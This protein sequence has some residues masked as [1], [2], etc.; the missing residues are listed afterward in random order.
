MAKEGEET[1]EKEVMEAAPPA[2]KEENEVVHADTTTVADKEEVQK[3]RAA[4][5]GEKPKADEEALAPPPPPPPAEAEAGAPPAAEYDP[6]NV[7]E[8][9]LDVKDDATKDQGE[10]PLNLNPIRFHRFDR[11]IL[12]SPT[13]DPRRFVFFFLVFARRWSSCCPWRRGSGVRPGPRCLPGG[14]TSLRPACSGRIRR[15]GGSSGRG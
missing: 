13:T 12:G 3:E 5:S 7:D 1:N 4:P 6:E 2:A 14:S 15:R 8:Q 10:L 9:P 11:L